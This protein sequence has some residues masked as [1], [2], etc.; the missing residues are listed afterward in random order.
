VAAAVGLVQLVVMV[1]EQ[2]VVHLEVSVVMAAL[3]L[4]LALQVLQ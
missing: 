1:A 3:E 2:A 4:R